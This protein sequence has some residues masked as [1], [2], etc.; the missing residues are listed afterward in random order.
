M[1]PACG[2]SNRDGAIRSLGGRLPRRQ[3]VWSIADVIPAG[4]TAAVA[5]LE[6]RWAIPIRDA[7]SEAGGVPLADTWLHPERQLAVGAR[8]GSSD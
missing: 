6:H 2:P 3:A 8:L 7:I 4:S 5:L 1:S